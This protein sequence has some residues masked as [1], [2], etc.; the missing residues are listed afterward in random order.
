MVHKTKSDAVGSGG[1]QSQTKFAVLKEGL[2]TKYNTGPRAIGTDRYQN[3]Y[4]LH[5]L[6]DLKVV[7]THK[8]D[9]SC[10][11]SRDWFSINYFRIWGFPV[12]IESV[13]IDKKNSYHFSLSIL[14]KNRFHQLTTPCP[15]DM[16]YKKI[17]TV[18]NVTQ[19]DPKLTELV[20]EVTGLKRWS[21]KEM[22]LLRLKI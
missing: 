9:N 12:F 3:F 1:L 13:F 2:I 4:T 18:V 19:P 15:I 16:R 14:Y 10:Q 8:V 6:K 21:T 5:S 17:S 22:Y 7:T 11:Y 20:V